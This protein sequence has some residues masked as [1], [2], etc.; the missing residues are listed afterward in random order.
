MGRIVFCNRVNTICPRMEKN[1]CS[2]LC[3]KRIKSRA[4]SDFSQLENILRLEVLREPSL[5]RN[6][7]RRTRLKNATMSTGWFA[8]DSSL[9]IRI[10]KF[11]NGTYVSTYTHVWS[12]PLDISEYSRVRYPTRIH[13]TLSIQIS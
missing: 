13:P 2:T 10:R 6:T 5:R 3:C 8:R 4:R 1:S 9:A 11:L 12:V 7:R